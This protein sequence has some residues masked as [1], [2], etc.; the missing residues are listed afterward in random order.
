MTRRFSNFARNLFAFGLFAIPGH[1]AIALDDVEFFEKN[2]R[3][4]FI[5]RCYECHSSESKK[6]KGGLRLDSKHGWSVGGDTGPAIV[7]GDPDASLVIKAVRH[8]IPD[9]EMPPKERLPAHE[10]DAL[11]KWIK[12]GAPDPRTNDAPLVEES[13][14]VEKGREFWSFKPP[15]FSAIPKLNESR[16]AENGD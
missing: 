9:L 13:I 3:P 15:V 10:I 1:P 11:V 7:P 12:M 14:S 5:E 6:L 4:I 2:V 8:E 16:L